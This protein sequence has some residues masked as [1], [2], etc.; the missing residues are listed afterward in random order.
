MSEFPFAL[1]W[2]EFEFEFF[3]LR[4]CGIPLF[5]LV[6]RWDAR[7]FLPVA[8]DVAVQKLQK[9]LPFFNVLMYLGNGRVRM[10]PVAA[11]LA[12]ESATGGIGAWS[13]RFGG[14]RCGTGADV[15]R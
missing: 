2:C 10:A 14:C 7:V 6:V 12:E 8:L 13:S 9:T 15:Q 5:L 3:N 11:S 1:E 4:C